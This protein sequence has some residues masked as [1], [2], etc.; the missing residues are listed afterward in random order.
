VEELTAKVR[1]MYVIFS[2]LVLN[3]IAIPSITFAQDGTSENETEF[4]ENDLNSNE[5]PIFSFYF[6]EE[7]GFFPVNN[8]IL[9]DNLSKQIVHVDLISDSISEEMIQNSG[10]KNL[11]KAIQVAQFFDLKPMYEGDGYDTRK[12]LLTI[13]DGEKSNTVSWSDDSQGSSTL[14]KIITQIKKL[15]P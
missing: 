7:G 10:T 8:Y 13:T 2:I 5:T 4:E 12:Y 11:R 3:C 14:N 15:L 9:F 1:K 6:R